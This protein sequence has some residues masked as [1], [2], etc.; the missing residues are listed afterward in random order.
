MTSNADDNERSSDNQAFDSGEMEDTDVPSPSAK[1]KLTTY[2]NGTAKSDI[3]DIL[4][5]KGSE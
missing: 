3:D 5:P 2:P 4:A 1:V